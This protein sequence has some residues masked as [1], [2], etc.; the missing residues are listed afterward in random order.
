MAPRADASG[1]LPT[2]RLIGDRSSGRP[3]GDRRRQGVTVHGPTPSPSV[4]APMA[5]SGRARPHPSPDRRTRNGQ[6]RLPRRP[7]RPGQARSA[8]RIGRRS[9]SRRSHG[10]DTRGLKGFG[11]GV[12]ATAMPR[13]KRGRERTTASCGDV[14]A[15]RAAVAP[16]SRSRRAGMHPLRAS[17][18]AFDRRGPSIP[19]SRAPLLPPLWDE[20]RL[21]W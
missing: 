19:C 13:G 17:A 4:R 12:T 21:R 9:S 20:V 6:P 5:S 2:S 10:H 15:H 18:P 8:R 11:G 7:S 14:R 16:P 3:V 1:V